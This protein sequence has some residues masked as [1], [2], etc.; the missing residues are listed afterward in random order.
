MATL[1]EVLGYEQTTVDFSEDPESVIRAQQNLQMLEKEDPINPVDLA[2]II[3]LPTSTATKRNAIKSGLDGGGRL[4]EELNNRLSNI[5]PE[6]EAA[7]Q[8]LLQNSNVLQAILAN[9]ARNVQQAGE[10]KSQ[11]ILL[12]QAHSEMK[13]QE[14][15]AFMQRAG[16]DIG[17]IDSAVNHAAIQ[18]PGLYMQ[19]DALQKEI[20]RKASTSFFNDPVAW[21]M[22]QI[23][24]S[25]DVAKH[26]RL[27]QQYNSKEEFVKSAPAAIKTAIDSNAPK[28]TAM[29]SMEANNLAQQQL[30]AAQNNVDKIQEEAAKAG[31]QTGKELRGVDRQITGDLLTAETRKLQEQDRDRAAQDR[32]SNMKRLE[33]ESE[34][35]EFEHRERLKMAKDAADERKLKAERAREEADLQRRRDEIVAAA[36]PGMNITSQK[37]LQALSP[38]LRAKYEAIVNNYDDT[39]GYAKLGP[40]PM[41]VLSVAQGMKKSF[42]GN[43]YQQMMVESVAALAHKFDADKKGFGMKPEE[44]L[45]AKNKYITDEIKKW[46][47][48][49]TTNGPVGRDGEQWKA[50]NILPIGEIATRPTFA[51]NKFAIET[52]TLKSTL[53]QGTEPTHSMV[54]TAL[55]QKSLQEK[56]ISQTAKEI[57]EFYKQAIAYNNAALTPD[58]FALPKQETFNVPLPTGTFGGN[59]LFDLASVSGATQALIQMQKM[60]ILQSA[61]QSKSLLYKALNP[62]GQ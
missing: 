55:A 8:E 13:A 6:G 32:E 19:M 38:K 10:L 25:E 49:P 1:D 51:N 41:D 39:E 3:T 50:F 27:A 20:D 14:A 11:E 40:T 31:I 12:K 48:R 33:R 53:P 60:Q 46:Q 23:T 59:V 42:L 4:S 17:Q 61:P 24:V 18:L 43:E 16:V 58:R 62:N 9:Q 26:N 21:I 15:G 57:S 28:F 5:I 45:A 34:F 36:L 29:T 30:L 7:K 35:R 52:N 37:Q 22:D 54:M 2:Q 44:A 56:N 47:D